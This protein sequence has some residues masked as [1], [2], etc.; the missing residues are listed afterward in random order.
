MKYSKINT[1]FILKSE[2]FLFF[3]FSTLKINLQ[4]PKHF[5]HVIFTLFYIQIKLKVEIK[6]A[7]LIFLIVAPPQKLVV[8]PGATIRDNTVIYKKS[9]ISIRGGARS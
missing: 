3:T 8:A 7:S 5:F 6:V 4:S 9:S 2:L 1:Y